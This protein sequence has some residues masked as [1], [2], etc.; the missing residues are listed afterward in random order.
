MYSPFT[1]RPTK[2]FSF[3]CPLNV[4][5]WKFV[6][7]RNHRI[8]C[9]Y[10]S[11]INQRKI[12]IVTYWYIILNIPQSQSTVSRCR[13]KLIV[14]QKFHIGNSFPMPAENMQ[15]LAYVSQVIVM[16]V[17]ICRT[18]LQVGWVRYTQMELINKDHLFNIHCSKSSRTERNL[19]PHDS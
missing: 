4:R 3:V 7:A 6:K 16:N 9:T 5:N 14:G 15:W 2:F 1:V 8:K 18:H 12:S 19:R 13:S 11:F 10:Y 17:M